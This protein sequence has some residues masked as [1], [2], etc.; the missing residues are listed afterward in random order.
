VA[1]SCAR[2]R[3]AFEHGVEAVGE[4]AIVIA[5]Q[6]TNRGRA[7]T[8]FM[9]HYNSYRLHRGCTLG[10]PRP[11]PRLSTALVRKRWR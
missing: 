3:R 5:N 9:D 10:H 4:L 6:K 1:S 2:K 11:G 7:R 8:V